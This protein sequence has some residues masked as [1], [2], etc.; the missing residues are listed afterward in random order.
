VLHSYRHVPVETD[1]ALSFLALK[2][3]DLIDVLE[4]HASGWWEGSWTVLADA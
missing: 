3:G 2:E 4:M 1:R